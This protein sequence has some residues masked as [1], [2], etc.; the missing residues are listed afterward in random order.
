MLALAVWLPLC[1]AQPLMGRAAPT[2]RDMATCC[3][4]MAQNCPAMGTPSRDCCHMRMAAPKPAALLTAAA[5]PT[6][7]A[8]GARTAAPGLVPQRFDRRGPASNAP[9]RPDPALQRISV[10]LI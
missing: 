10:L 8:A 9:P 5:A 3:Q 1:C 4:Q 6:P 2:M 7:L